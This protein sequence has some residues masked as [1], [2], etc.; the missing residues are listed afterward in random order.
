MIQNY[1]SLH[2]NWRS[3]IPNDI[4]YSTQ[5]SSKSRFYYPNQLI[6]NSMSNGEEL[7]ERT[8]G[9]LS[10]H[11]GSIFK[12]TLQL[13]RTFL[14]LV[15][16][17]ME[18][19][20]P[21][22]YLGSD[23]K[24]SKTV[25]FK[26]FGFEKNI[27][28]KFDDPYFGELPRQMATKGYSIITL[29][30]P[31]GPNSIFSTFKDDEVKFVPIFSFLKPGQ[32]VA[33]YLNSLRWI[34]F[35][36]PVDDTCRN[37]QSKNILKKELTTNTTFLNLV[38]RSCFKN[39][40]D[41]VELEK[42]F[43]T[44]EN[45]PWERMLLFEAR[46]KRVKT[47]GHQHIPFCPAALNFYVGDH[48]K[49]QVLPDE[50]VSTGKVPKNQMQS[51]YGYPEEKL[52]EG[53]GFR[54]KTLDKKNLKGSPRNVK[55]VLVALGGTVESSFLLDYFLS[56]H[57]YFKSNSIEVVFRFHPAFKLESFIGHLKEYTEERMKTFSVSEN[58]VMDDLKWAEVLVYWGSTISFEALAFGVL[59]VNLH[60]D[61]E[62]L[63][64]DQL[65]EYENTRV[66][67][68]V[69]TL[70]EEVFAEVNKLLEE[71]LTAKLERGRDYQLDYL[72]ENTASERERWINRYFQL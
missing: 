38:Y 9:R 4:W 25:A 72:G 56:N 17:W 51:I 34:F 20:R 45:Y 54:Y 29:V 1:L 43:Y 70:V 19:K 59:L 2:A 71:D 65:F 41:T 49:E 28:K 39:F 64:N 30:D 55:R 68:T 32:I 58:S 35:G 16:K 22:Y 31:V 15:I 57:D 42:I 36:A 40:F 27:G 14:S 26:T 37:N 3:K 11:Y 21:E 50:I 18:Y 7:D 8:L 69:N 63:S 67:R 53:I 66:S 44:F 10:L 46:K 60:P 24:S 5:I 6:A 47:V 33:L 48:E 23:F 12:R 52:K 13:T 62:F 61:D